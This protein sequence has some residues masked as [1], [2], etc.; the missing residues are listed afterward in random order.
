MQARAIARPPEA[1]FIGGADETYCAAQ[2]TRQPSSRLPKASQ[3][4]GDDLQYPDHFVERLHRLWGVGFLSPGGPQEVKEIAR[5]FDLADKTV[6]DIG[7]GTGGPSIVLARDLGAGRV[8]AIDVEAPLLARAAENAAAEGV[9]DR[10]AFERVE[11]GPL[12]F[13]DE[14]FDLV[15]SKDALIHIADKAAIYR[16]ALRVLQPGGAFVASDWLGG[17]NTAASADWQRYRALGHL[18]FT[19]ATAAET[20]ATMTAA[21]F[22]RVSTRDR[23]AWYADLSRFELEQ[24][25][26]PLRDELIAAVGEE[27]YD[28]WRQVRR[29]LAGAAASGALRPTHLRGYKAFA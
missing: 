29:A 21:G 4:I 16:E 22:D 2:R 19:M 23:N 14:S 10:I 7:C 9:A 6:L 12:P 5:D 20:E 11:P 1:S 27:I 26:G 8:I 3:A 28:H 17:D 24:I 15:F 13:G 25:E 18:D